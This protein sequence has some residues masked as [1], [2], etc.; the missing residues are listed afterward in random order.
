MSTPD[1]GQVHDTQHNCR[2]SSISTKSLWVTCR[3]HGSVNCCGLSL[4]SPAIRN[5]LSVERLHVNA[6]P[7]TTRPAVRETAVNCLVPG[8]R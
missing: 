3:V 1:K 6:C 7:S 2:H 5:E 8:V 4:D